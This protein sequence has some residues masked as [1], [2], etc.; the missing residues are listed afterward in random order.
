MNITGP[1]GAILLGIQNFIHRSNQVPVGVLFNV[2]ALTEEERETFWRIRSDL[3]DAHVL[4]RD[5]QKA[6]RGILDKIEEY[7]KRSPMQ[8]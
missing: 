3:A 1:E 2:E 5:D 8:C 4:E 7:I 6:F